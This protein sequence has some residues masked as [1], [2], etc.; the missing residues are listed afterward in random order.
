MKIRILFV[1]ALVSTMAS[2]AWAARD[3]QTANARFPILVQCQGQT[4]GESSWLREGS[5]VN[6]RAGKG[7][8]WTWTGQDGRPGPYSSSE[9]R[10]DCIAGANYV[11]GGRSIPDPERVLIARC[12]LPDALVPPIY[13][14]TLLVSSEGAFLVSAEGAQDLSGYPSCELSINW[15]NL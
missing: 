7:T 2:S 8:L 9:L 11:A 1:I 10:G 4:L 13:G 3:L 15:A 14:K 12:T 5:L 6:L